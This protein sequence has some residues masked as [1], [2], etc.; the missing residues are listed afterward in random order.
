MS[1]RD[2]RD[3]AKRQIGNRTRIQED[4]WDTWSF[5]PLDNSLRQLR[6][7]FRAA[8]KSMGYSLTVIATLAL[9]IGATVTIFSVL[10]HVL[11]RPLQYPHADQLVALYEHG[12][13]GNQRLVSY[14]TLL[15]WSH[16]GAGFSGMAYVRG[17]GVSLAMPD[18]PETVVAAFVSQGFFKLMETRP[19]LGR[20]FV[21][22]EELQSGADAVVLSHDLWVHYFDAIQT[23][24]AASCRWT[25]QR[26]P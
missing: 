10:D 22:E 14:P 18:G 9:G 4:S 20:T 17:D 13:E 15:D 7:A 19:E 6:M 1:E 5:G 8:R 25:A 24:S 26:L 16:G 2:A 11:M 3:A 12:A 23:S 21:P